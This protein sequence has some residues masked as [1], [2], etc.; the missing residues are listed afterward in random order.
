MPLLAINLS[1]KLFR[2]IKELVED[3]KYDSFE[4]FLEIAAFNQL[5]LGRGAAPSDVIARGHW[6]GPALI[7]EQEELINAGYRERRHVVARA[8][9]KK[10]GG[11]VA[12]QVFLLDEVSANEEES[13]VLK[14]FTLVAVQNGPTPCQAE[15]VSVEHI[16]GQVNRLF[17]LK[18]ACRWIATWTFGRSEKAEWP[19]YTMISDTLGDDAAKLGSLLERGD[20]VAA[21]KRDDQLATGLPRR[22][23]SASRDRFLTQFLARLTRAGE[24][25]PGAVCQY[26]L[27]RFLDGRLALTHEGV[28][29]AQLRNP[30]LDAADEGV[31]DALSQEEVEFLTKQI[32]EWAHGERDDMRI[33][34][35]AVVDGNTT[36]AALMQS[37]RSKLPRQWTQ[38]MALT[39][40]SGLVA[41]LADLRLIRRRWQ[42][43]NVE[44][45]LGDCRRIDGFLK[46]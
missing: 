26:Q 43:R 17:P 21:R 33:V 12:R 34:L 10:T 15:A 40:V 6:N 8:P 44:Y 23:N 35:S 1:D 16:F 5:A 27:A 46:T 9:R 31:T 45:E 29:F 28:A 37:V 18:I 42:G 7:Y 14:P 24:M 36:P 11:R 20:A 25:Y 39:H 19:V 41:R 30:I 38:S 22:S 4:G 13:T 2:D 3:G 32:L